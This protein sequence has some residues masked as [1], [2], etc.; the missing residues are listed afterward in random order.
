MDLSKYGFRNDF[1]CKYIICVYINRVIDMEIYISVSMSILMQSIYGY[2][3]LSIYIN[4]HGERLGEV[5]CPTFSYHW[6]LKSDK[7]CFRFLIFLFI[8]VILMAPLKAVQASPFLEDF[9]GILQTVS[10]LLPRSLGLLLSEHFLPYLL[11]PCTPLIPH[12]CVP[13]SVT[14]SHCANIERTSINVCSTHI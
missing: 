2:K 7:D 12:H 5:S 10:C 14:C 11:R 1:K 9:F 6:K 4:S 3:Y 13:P 8:W